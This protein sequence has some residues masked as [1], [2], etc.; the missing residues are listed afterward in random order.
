MPIVIL[1]VFQLFHAE[2][3]EVVDE[4]TSSAADLP[5]PSVAASGTAEAAS[6]EPVIVDPV[7]QELVRL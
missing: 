2:A 6:P 5:E 4:A 1:K 3:S 7:V